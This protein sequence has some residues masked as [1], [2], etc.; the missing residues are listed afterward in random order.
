MTPTAVAP[1]RR[2]SE[3]WP[4]RR[5]S[6][7]SPPSP[8]CLWSASGG[9]VGAFGAGGAWPC[10]GSGRCRAR[11]RRPRRGVA[12][13]A[14][15]GPACGKSS[16]A[17]VAGL[18]TPTPG[19]VS[20]DGRTSPRSHRTRQALRPDVPGPRAGSPPRRDRHVAFG[21]T[22][23]ARGAPRRRVAPCRAGP[24]GARGFDHRD[25]RSLSAGSSSGSRW[26]GRW[27]RRRGCSCSDDR[28]DPSTAGC[29]RTSPPSCDGLRRARPHRGLRPRPSG[30]SP[31]RPR[32]VMDH[33]R[34]CSRYT[35][36]RSETA[37]RRS[38][39]AS[40]ASPT[41]STP[42]PREGW[43]CGPTV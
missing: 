38:R 9:E 39:H 14:V 15:P 2:R 13:L 10:S 41:S 23:R 12:D 21:P 19:T 27:R 11:R 7:L 18:E 30:P 8:C 42:A 33:G 35:R 31:S 34:G 32:R 1:R 37:D 26:A 22:C 40:W 3:R 28:S 29:G 20:W 36:S 5:S 6:W 24:R 43:P 16:S 4:R 17:T 25:V